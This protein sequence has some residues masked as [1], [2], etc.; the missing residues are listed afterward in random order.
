MTI[1][2]VQKGFWRVESGRIPRPG[3]LNW[4]LTSFVLLGCA[5]ERPGLGQAL[6]VTKV[7]PALS[8]SIASGAGVVIVNWTNGSSPFQVQCCSKLG[9]VWQDVAVVTSGFSQTNIMVQPCAFYRV[10]SVASFIA[11]SPDKQAPSIPTGLTA[12]ATNCGQ[13]NLS[14]TASTDTGTSASGLKGY[15]VYRGGIFL[16]QV[17]APATTT[18]DTG[19]TPLT[20]YTY[21]V[22][23]VDKAYN[24]SSRSSAATATTPVCPVCA[25]SIA[26]TNASFAATGGSNSVAVTTGGGCPWTASSS[27]SWITITAGS[28]A[29]GNG[30]VS[31]LV[32]A[33]TATNTRSG[34]MTRS[35]ER[36]V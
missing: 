10:A 1:M 26:P 33:N 35:E 5:L 28:S 36:R 11:A 7:A 32:A 20:S 19:L 4:L 21:T 30:I 18:S 29:A 31:Y 27:A 15:N 8:S 9:G 16:K 2:P 3:V 6:R 14:W 24:Q 25:F 13:I 34:G 12:T 23:S 17:L 22:S